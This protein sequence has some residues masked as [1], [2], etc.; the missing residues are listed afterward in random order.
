MLGCAPIT[1]RRYVERYP[2]CAEALKNARVLVGN[3]GSDYG[4]QIWDAS[5]NLMWDLTD[6]ATTYGLKN[7]AV[8]DVYDAAGSTGALGENNETTIATVGIGGTH[9]TGL[10]T[11]YGNINITLAAGASIYLTVRRATVLG[12]I[13]ASQMFTNVLSGSTTYQVTVMGM[14]T[15]PAWSG[16]YILRGTALGDDATV[17]ASSMIVT[18]TKK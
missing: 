13:V 14:D 5:G 1:I 15:D 4:V 2:I 6:G 17:N 16:N 9:Q 10:V 3:T 18:H 12:G 8:T 11:I 7:T